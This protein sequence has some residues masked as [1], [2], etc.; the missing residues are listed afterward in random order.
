MY[1]SKFN[2][3]LFIQHLQDDYKQLITTDMEE[4]LP[5]LWYYS[6]I[7]LEELKKTTQTS[8]LIVSVSSLNLG[9]PEYEAGVTT[10]GSSPNVKNFWSVSRLRAVLIISLHFF[11]VSSTLPAKNKQ[12]QAVT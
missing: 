8:D 12:Q 1:I 6:S 9:L 4:L 7:C 5:V 10:L 11:G 3:T 2:N